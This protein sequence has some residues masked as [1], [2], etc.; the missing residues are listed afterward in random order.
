MPANELE[1][2]LVSVD[3]FVDPGGPAP[4]TSVERTELLERFGLFGIRA[5]VDLVARGAA[6][7]SSR[8]AEELVSLSGLTGLRRL[9]MQQFGARRDVLKARAALV[10]LDD[11]FRADPRGGVGCPRRRART[12]HG[13]RP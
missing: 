11:V 4:L 9:L 1:R 13:R 7:T 6:P 12:D 5:S 2:L 8:M 3:D 10:V